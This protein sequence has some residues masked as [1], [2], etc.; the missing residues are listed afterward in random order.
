MAGI[1]YIMIDPLTSEV[2]YVGKTST[3]EAERLRGHLSD[4]KRTESKQS[5]WVRSLSLKGMQPI[6]EQIDSYNSNG[7][8]LE[9]YWI[10]QFK[11]WGFNL[12]NEY[13]DKS[14]PNSVR[15]KISKGRI[16]MK[17]S[18]RHRKNIIISNSRGLYEVF[19]SNKSIGKFDSCGEISKSLG[20][21]ERSVCR[22]AVSGNE[23]KRRLVKG[24][25]II[26][27]ER[28]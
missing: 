20:L 25:Q 4:S 6:I 15:E 13:F 9:F 16:G 14:V 5:I 28:N 8:E 24:I 27:H 10:W 3:T 23:G 11:T 18:K 2:K 21:P 7:D 19:K 26:R 12:N 22:L 1:I 17:F